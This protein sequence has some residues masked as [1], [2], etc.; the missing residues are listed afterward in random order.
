[1]DDPKTKIAI[2]VGKEIDKTVTG[3]FLFYNKELK[4]PR[5]H[6]NKFVFT[7]I[8]NGYNNFSSI[9]LSDEVYIEEKDV[10]PLTVFTKKDAPQNKKD[11]NKYFLGLY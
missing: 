11:K 5:I 8:I 9:E 1:M 2:F 10:K 3:H 6:G 4:H 7:V